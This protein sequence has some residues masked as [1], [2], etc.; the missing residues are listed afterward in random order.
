MAREV[1][2]RGREV[3]AGD[4]CQHESNTHNDQTSR[5]K[6][7]THTEFQAQKRKL[8]GLSRC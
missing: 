7:D 3:E 6:I 8:S 4:G 2:G 5:L 1:R